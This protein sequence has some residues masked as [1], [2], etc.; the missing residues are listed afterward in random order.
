MSP[1]V[2]FYNLCTILCGIPFEAHHYFHESKS[3]SLAFY[4]PTRIRTELLISM[5]RHGLTDDVCKLFPAFN[6]LLYRL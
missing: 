4:N 1:E 2:V 3:V 5:F 6:I